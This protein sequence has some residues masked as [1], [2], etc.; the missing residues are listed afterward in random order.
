[1]LVKCILW[2]NC[3]VFSHRVRATFRRYN[4]LRT[5]K[6][7]L[8][9]FSMRSSLKFYKYV[10]VPKMSAV[11][12]WSRCF[13]LYRLSKSPSSKRINAIGRFCYHFLVE[14]CMWNIAH[15]Y[16][17]NLH[18]YDRIPYSRE[19]LFSEFF[20]FACDDPFSYVVE[21]KNTLCKFS[22]WSDNVYPCPTGLKIRSIWF[23]ENKYI[24]SWLM[25]IS[26]E[27]LSKYVSWNVRFFIYFW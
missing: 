13:K 25:K 18:N 11:F 6:K 2:V 15:T 14:T 24:K 26:L 16:V 20:N 4:I 3:E 21:Y 12:C 27:I 17:S 8:R 9:C 5:P 23:N 7:N 1:L 10:L 22:T 19:D